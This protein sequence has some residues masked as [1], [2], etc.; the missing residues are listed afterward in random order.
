MNKESQRQLNQNIDQL[1]SRLI[2]PKG[3]SPIN[4]CLIRINWPDEDFCYDKAIG[5]SGNNKDP[6]HPDL[7]FR[8]GSISKIFTAVLI[9]QLAEE[10]YLDINA[11]FLQF[12]DEKQRNILKDLH[13]YEGKSCTLK[14]RVSDLL[15]HSS[16]LCD[17]YSEDNKFVDFL[18]KNPDKSWTWVDVIEKFYTWDYPSRAKFLP[19]QAT[20][21]SDTNYLLLALLAEQRSGK[22]LRDL[23]RERIFNP[24]GLKNTFL[25]YYDPIS[26]GSGHL[27]PYYGMKSME[28]INTSFDWGAGGLLSK[29][30]DLDHFI[31]SLFQ[32]ALFKK[33]SSLEA[34]KSGIEGDPEGGGSNKELFGAGLQVKQIGKSKLFGHNS[35]YGGQLFYIPDKNIS[36]IFTLN[37]A[38]AFLKSEWLL[39]AICKE[40]L[41]F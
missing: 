38:R 1:I 29:L 37:Q 9:L 35:A 19:G 5:V 31:R 14:I 11:T 6:V 39:R 34:M 7:L 22:K 8:T 16:G 28:Q 23:Y 10:D 33:S 13:V 25:E 18:G 2:N 3:E 30:D 12:L 17:Y 15:R 21:Y 20:H 4:N 40:V 24:L 27:F 26:P 41:A 36:I 32:G